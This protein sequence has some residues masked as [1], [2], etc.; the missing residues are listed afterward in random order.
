MRRMLS[1]VVCRSRLEIAT[2]LLGSCA[3]TPLQS[4]V[5]LFAQESRFRF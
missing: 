3:I 5:L 2:T 1:S 4:Q